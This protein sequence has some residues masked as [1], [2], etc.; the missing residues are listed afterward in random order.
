MGLFNFFKRDTDKRTISNVLGEFKMI[1][2]GGVKAYEGRI[3]SKIGNDIA[4]A[5]VA[6]DGGIPPDRIEYFRKLEN[7][8]DVVL[9]FFATN[10]PDLNFESYKPARVGIPHKNQT[11]EEFTEITLGNGINIMTLVLV[12]SNPNEKLDV[13]YKID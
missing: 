1:K 9:D 12:G 3:N 11:D 8:W 13:Y 4:V 5:F 7:N 10:N 6:V 2:V